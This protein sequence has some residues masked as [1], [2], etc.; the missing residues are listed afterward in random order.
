MPYLAPFPNHGM[1]EDYT[2]EY[3]LLKSSTT[4]NSFLTIFALQ[5]NSNLVQI[6]LVTALFF[7]QSCA[8]FR[9]FF[10]Y[11]V[12]ALDYSFIWYNDRI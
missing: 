7:P 8:V 11:K 5:F 6:I 10:L 3:S 12:L 4:P 1:W 9:F 2:R